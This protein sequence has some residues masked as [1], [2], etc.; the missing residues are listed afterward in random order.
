MTKSQTAI[1]STVKSITIT[2]GEPPSAQRV[3]KAAV[4][5]DGITAPWNP[6]YFYLFVWNFSVGLQ[7][8]L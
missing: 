2:R 5:P 4:R 6:E 3:K 1:I 8:S 7:S